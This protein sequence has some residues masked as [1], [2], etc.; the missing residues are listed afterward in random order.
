MAEKLI[1]TGG[2]WGQTIDL[3]DP[4]PVAGQDSAAPPPDDLTTLQADIDRFTLCAERA[5]MLK[6]LNGATLDK[7][8]ESE[9][10]ADTSLENPG[11][12][13]RTPT[14][15]KKKQPPVPP[16]SEEALTSPPGESSGSAPAEGEWAIVNIF[17]AG[18]GLQVRLRK[19]DGSVAQAKTGTVLA[20]GWTVKQVSTAGVTLTKGGQDKLLTWMD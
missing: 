10:K 12:R 9:E 6:R 2:E 7:D 20:D 1:G 13:L 15:G 18:Q 19:D 14:A 17:G 5:E 3:N 4:C 16:V 8:T 11:F